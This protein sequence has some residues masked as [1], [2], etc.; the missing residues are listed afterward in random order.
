M[1]HYEAQLVNLLLIESDSHIRDNFV[2]YLKDTHLN[3]NLTEATTGEQGIELMQNNHFDCVLL[4]NELAD[5]SGHMVL[6]FIQDGPTLS[7]PVIVYSDTQ[8]AGLD[9]ELLESGAVEFIPKHLC[10]GLLLRRVI[11]YCLVRKQYLKSQRDYL[12]SQKELTEQQAWYEEESKIEL[13]KSEKEHAEA[14][15]RAK[16]KFLSNMSHELRTPLNAILG[17]AQL[18]TLKSKNPLSDDQQD[19]IKEIIKAGNHLLSLINDVLD[20]SKIEAGK[21]D[22]RREEVD[23]AQMIAECVSLTRDLAQLRECQ[24]NYRCNQRIVIKADH[25]RFKQVLLNLMT[26]AIKYN[27]QNGSVD[28]DCQV[29]DEQMLQINVK[30]SGI[31]IARELFDQVFQPFSRLTATNTAVEGTGIGLTLSRRL[32]EEMGGTI[33]FDSE[34]GQGS[35]FWLKIPLASQLKTPNP[36]SANTK[37]RLLYIDGNMDNIVLFKQLWL[38]REVENVLDLLACDSMDVAMK[39]ARTKVPDLLIIDLAQLYLPL[40]E[41]ICAIRQQ[42]TLSEV[43]TVAVTGQKTPEVVTEGLK[44]GFDQVL[45]KPL[46]IEQIIELSLSTLSGPT[47]R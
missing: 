17:F 31:G 42:P 44:A 47:T 25:T 46:S 9:L 4:D 27:K 6:L 20:L 3:F 12:D 28:I 33:G 13:L 10:N 37:R 35:H 8:Q 18:L 11:L 21:I 23:V 29:C 39:L 36:D 14:A 30:D 43:Q 38:E 24:V 26:N 16:S 2:Q 32:V 34:L 1:L 41:V 19:N 40:D 22:I 7:V 45:C 5:M 15:N